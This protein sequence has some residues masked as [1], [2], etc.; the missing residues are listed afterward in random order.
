MKNFILN[1]EAKKVELTVRVGID[2]LQT[3]GWDFDEYH[4]QK[5]DSMDLT[6]EEGEQYNLLHYS[7]DIRLEGS[8]GKVNTLFTWY[9]HDKNQT[10]EYEDTGDDQATI[11]DILYMLNDESLRINENWDYTTDENGEYVPTFIEKWDDFTFVEENDGE[12]RTKYLAFKSEEEAESYIEKGVKNW[13]TN[14]IDGMNDEEVEE[15]ARGLFNIING[16]NASY[17]V[18]ENAEL[19]F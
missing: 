10:T 16:I 19:N 2:D 8:F 9:H 6:F 5:A 17:S 1:P 4:Q 14:G 3:L 18:Y 13:I 12:E 7:V 15:Y 11:N